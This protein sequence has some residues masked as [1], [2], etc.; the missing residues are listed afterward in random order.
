MPVRHLSR[1]LLA[2]AVVLTLTAGTAAAQPCSQGEVSPTGT[3]PC[4]ACVPG[5]FQDQPGQTTCLDCAVGTFVPGPGSSVCIACPA[6]TFQDQPG[7]ATCLDC[8]PG[9]FVDVTGAAACAACP[10][11]RFQANSAATTCQDCAPG[12]AQPQQGQA[13]CP[14]C[15]PGTFQDNSGATTC[16]E[17]LAGTIAPNQ[18]T[19]VCENCPAGQTAP[20]ASTMCVSDTPCEPN[21]C[22][23][24]GT[25]NDLGLGAFECICSPDFM[26]P[27][28]A[29]PVATELNHFQCHEVDD[30]P[31]VPDPFKVIGLTDPFGS[32][33]NV[34]VKRL[35]RLCNPADKNNELGMVP[36]DPEHYL[37]YDVK[38]KKQNFPTANV[39]VVTQFGVLDITV[40]RPT[41]LFVPAS[42]DL[43]GP[44][45]ALN[46]V[47]VDHLLCHRLRGARFRQ[48]GIQVDDQL[49]SYLENIKKPFRLC[50]PVEKDVAGQITPV[51]NPD[52]H[53]LCYKVRTDPRRPAITG[54]IWATSQF[55]GLVFDVTR[56]REFCVP[57][58]IF[59]PTQPTA[60]PTLSATPTPTVTSTAPTV[61]PTPTLS[62]TPT[63]TVTSTATPTATL[64]ATPTATPTVTPTAT[65]TVTPT[66]TLTVTPTL[67]MT[68]TPTVTVT[69]TLTPRPTP[70][71]TGPTPTPT[72][73][74]ID[75]FTLYDVFPLGPDAPVVSLADQFH[76]VAPLV[77]D[78]GDLAFILNPAIKNGETPLDLRQHL[79]GYE[80]LGE[81]FGPVD[82]DIDNQF[83]PHTIRIFDPEFL[84]VPAEKQHPDPLP[85]PPLPLTIDHYLCYN[86]TGVPPGFPNPEWTDQFDDVP[87]TLLV[88]LLYFCNPVSKNGE[89]IR[90]FDQHLACY[91]FDTNGLQAPIPFFFRD[92]F[93]DDSALADFPVALCVP[94][95]KLNVVPVPTP[96][97]TPI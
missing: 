26:G 12:T 19:I 14:L 63:A 9:T 4:T 62:P 66:A 82:A 95:L 86:A 31:V 50:S 52:Q 92:Q 57:A 58:T 41:M 29:D 28:C 40:Q 38:T 21:P 68:P 3:E 18:G 79:T 97:S 48:D 72:I 94:S 78:L 87:A 55:G 53:L 33:A 60:T 1:V 7:Q 42:K 47:N 43:A 54:P 77:T 81:M 85:T 49:D 44:V 27:L 5:T 46:P 30:R 67:T 76:V 93:N 70:T 16:P 69:A 6:G 73:A 80:V 89:G 20:P 51:Q 90:N 10:A 59:D 11:G 15:A 25:C 84:A 37:A 8:Q 24:G 83:G 65:P 39:G 17:C 74:P 35:K 91:G 32:S 71:P 2:L 23:N 96:T 61:T 88:D 45:P 13:E 56:T 34:R 64:T 36:T 22:Q 75:H